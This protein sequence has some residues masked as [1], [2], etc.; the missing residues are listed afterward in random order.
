[1]FFVFLVSTVLFAAEPQPAPEA[2]E[3]GVALREAEDNWRAVEP[4]LFAVD[5]GKKF[6]GTDVRCSGSPISLREPVTIKLANGTV[7]RLTKLQ[8]ADREALSTFR[9]PPSI[10]TVWGPISAIDRDKRI[11]TIK[12][13]STMFEQWRFNSI[14]ENRSF[15]ICETEHISTK[16]GA[17]TACRGDR[18]RREAFPRLRRQRLTSW[19]GGNSRAMTKPW[20]L[21]LRRKN[22][23][24][25][26]FKKANMKSFIT[27]TLSF[28]ISLLLGFGS[29]FLAANLYYHA[30]ATSNGKPMPTVSQ[31]VFEHLAKWENGGILCIFMLPWALL[32]LYSRLLKKGEDLGEVE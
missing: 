10:V 16:S 18:A 22:E 6:I 20:L 23:I 27:L 15:P 21:A 28:V 12:A 4:A 9:K 29:E 25:R 26:H 24:I 8:G 2:V 11:V 13:V 19:R 17:K 5:T 1:V 31:W 3:I 7:V 30:K 32:L 14:D